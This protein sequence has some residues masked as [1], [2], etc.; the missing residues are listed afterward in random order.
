MHTRK[1]KWNNYVCM[2]CMYVCMQDTLDVE[3][4]GSGKIEG[5]PY[6]SFAKMMSDSHTSHGDIEVSYST[7]SYI[8]VLPFIHTYIPNRTNTLSDIHS[9]K[10]TY[11]HSYI[12]TYLHKNIH[13]VRTT[14]VCTYKLSV[15]K[16]TA[17]YTHTYKHTIYS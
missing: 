16:Y 1:N 7:R 17:I 9:L 3:L 5:T 12:H 2:Y 8:Y 14:F 15:H 11:V 6:G 10:Y 13:T 4:W